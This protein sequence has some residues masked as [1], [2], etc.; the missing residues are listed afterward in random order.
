MKSGLKRVVVV[1]GM[2]AGLAGGGPRTIA[3]EPDEGRPVTNKV[4]PAYPNIAKQLRLTGTVKLDALVTKEGRVKSTS[5][6][7]GHPILVAA[8]EDAARRWTYAP[9]DKET[10]ERMVFNFTS[11]E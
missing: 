11:P 10:H 6:I 5:V 8:A 3:A 1:V 2:L 4:A 9:A 7:G